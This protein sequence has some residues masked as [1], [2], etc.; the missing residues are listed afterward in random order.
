MGFFREVVV[1]GAALGDLEAEGV[2][3]G[4]KKRPAIENL[5]NFQ[6]K[7]LG[8]SYLCTVIIEVICITKDL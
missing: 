4:R 3:E 5:G 6:L 2:P 8:I 1:R 7:I